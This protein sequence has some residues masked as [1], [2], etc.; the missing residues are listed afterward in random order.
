MTF[1]TLIAALLMSA[2]PVASRADPALA[3]ALEPL[4]AFEGPGAVGSVLVEG[5]VVA[6]RAVGM[7]SVEHAAPLGPSTP[8]YVGSLAKHFVAGIAL[9]LHEQGRL[10]LDAPITTMLTELPTH[11][12]VVTGRDL[13]THTSGVRD[14]LQLAHHAGADLHQPMTRDEIQTLLA[15]QRRLDF[16]PGSDAVYSNSN[17]FLLTLLVE[18][19]SGEPLHALARL[20]FDRLGMDSTQFLVDGLEVIPGR[21]RG[22]QRLRGGD[23]RL[24]E[25]APPFEGLITTVDDLAK[26][27]VHLREMS[28]VD[29]PIL[30]ALI[31]P[32]TLADAQP[33]AS[34]YDAVDGAGALEIELD[35]PHAIATLYRAHPSDSRTGSNELAPTE[36]PNELSLFDLGVP[37]VLDLST[38]DGAVVATLRIDGRPDARFRRVDRPDVSAQKTLAGRYRSDELNATYHI[39]FEAGALSL[40]IERAD[41]R[42]VDRGALSPVTSDLYVLA[43]DPVTSLRPERDASGAVVAV[44]LSEPRLREVAFRR[45]GEARADRSE[46]ATVVDRLT[47]PWDRTGSPGGIIGVVRDGRLVYQ[48]SFGMANLEH[49]VPW[50]SRSTTEIR[51]MSKQFTAMAVLILAD[52]GLLSLDDDVRSHIPELPVYDAARPIT[53]R[54]LLYHTSG[55]RDYTAV[56]SF[57]GVDLH[58]E[59]TRDDLLKWILRQKGATSAPGEVFTYSNTGYFLLSLI[60]ERIS[61]TPFARF[62]RD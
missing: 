19:A 38:D 1:A 58:P 27:C 59:L 29:D 2:N 55:L 7:A 23:V 40:T 48:R 25:P 24:H 41:G 28:M 35:A 39:S 22:Y 56:M 5:Q 33:F 17:Y 43:R 4:A 36:R 50:S 54:D 21:A 61:G 46:L 9:K 31:T 45:I 10:D 32:A 52:E 6:T 11:Y 30:R 8:V 3:K 53:I 60:V 47:A 49:D 62:A 13:L 15:R 37:G 44:V 42:L 18:R 14:F 26:W 16:P 57:A 12:A 51:S 20:V 34:V